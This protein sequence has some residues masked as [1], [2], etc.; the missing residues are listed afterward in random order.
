MRKSHLILF[1]L[2]MLIFIS[3]ISV[4]Q[5]AWPEGDEIIVETRIDKIYYPIN[6]SYFSHPF[7]VFDFRIDYTI[8]VHKY[9]DYWN[10]WGPIYIP[11]SELSIN[12]TNYLSGFNFTIHGA[13]W[14]EHD[15]CTIEG[16]FT[17]PFLIANNPSDYELPLGNFTF[18]ITFYEGDVSWAY[19]HKACMNITEKLVTISYDTAKKV[20]TYARSKTDHTS[21]SL[22][23][24]LPFMIIITLRRKIS[25][26]ISKNKKVY[27]RIVR[28]QSL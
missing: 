20:D 3:Q 1:M 6:F 26:K 13:S 10:N 8:I 14:F 24:G 12:G 23:V 11:W 21:A 25:R 7:Y 27:H 19:Y 16:N 17:I 28:K 18:W 9:I 15:P 22:A 2:I 5:K 4:I